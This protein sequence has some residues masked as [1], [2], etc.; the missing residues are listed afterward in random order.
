MICLCVA[1]MLLACQPANQ[2]CGRLRFVGTHSLGTRSLGICTPYWLGVLT[3]PW[4]LS[5]PLEV[6]WFEFVTNQL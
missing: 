1:E 2:S 3:L 5:L 6:E 4:T